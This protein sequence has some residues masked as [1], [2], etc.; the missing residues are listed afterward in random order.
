[1]KKINSK[2]EPE[3]IP[4]EIL[5]LVMWN[6]I[7]VTQIA[8]K[9]TKLKVMRNHQR[10]CTA[11]CPRTPNLKEV[12]DNVNEPKLQYTVVSHLLVPCAN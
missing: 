11:G 1:M 12:K 4:K 6:A 9:F 10:I 8:F 5:P 7:R 3:N 2:T